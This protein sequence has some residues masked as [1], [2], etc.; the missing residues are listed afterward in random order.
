[1][2]VRI[3][4]LLC[5]LIGLAV[6]SARADEVYRRAVPQP[7]GNWPIIVQA[8]QIATWTSGSWKVLALNGNVYIEQGLLRLH[9]PRALFWVDAKSAQATNLSKTVLIAEGEIRLEDSDQKH[10]PKQAIIELAT[11]G[12]IKVKSKAGR[13]EQTSLE[14]S[15]FYREA[16]PLLNGTHLKKDAPMGPKPIAATN[17]AEPA[18]TIIPVAQVELQPPVV[19]PPLPGGAPPLDPVPSEGLAPSP[20]P[21]PRTPPALLFNPDLPESPG[22]LA[23]NTPRPPVREP[24]FPPGLPQPATPPAR[25]GAPIIKDIPIP[26]DMISRVL[27]I[28]PRF[29]VPY[30]LKFL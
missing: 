21:M 12:E 29:G 6:G 20:T 26:S 7:V 4:L 2:Q 9:A 11:R 30:N 25:L 18:S 10:E 23:P 14:S 17:K 22:G 5:L 24:I 8:D 3:R 16:L 1:M 27:Q 28:A 15:A 13:I 19:T